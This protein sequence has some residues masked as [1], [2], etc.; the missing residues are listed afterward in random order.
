MIKNL[1]TVEKANMTKS[2]WMDQ[3]RANWPKA[4]VKSGQDGMRACNGKDVVGKFNPTED[5]V[6]VRDNPK[7]ME[8]AAFN[9]YGYQSDPNGPTAPYPEYKGTVNTKLATTAVFLSVPK[10]VILP[11]TGNATAGVT[12]TAITLMVGVSP[13][14]TKLSELAACIASVEGLTLADVQPAKNRGL[15]VS[16]ILLHPV[17][18]KDVA[19]V[20][21]NLV[22]TLIKAGY[23]PGKM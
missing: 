19:A 7:I 2:Q 15:V 11:G 4:V 8:K 13:L 16:K 3:V 10:A 6:Y 21:S 23:T 1:R 5:D 14:F 18:T 17:T 9:A 20:I 12:E 22:N